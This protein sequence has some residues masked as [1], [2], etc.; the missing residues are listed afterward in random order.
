MAFG[1]L[2]VLGL[3]QGLCE[4]LP[5]SSSGHLVLLSSLFGI[6]DS[7]LVSVILH[8]ATLLAVLI[9]FRKDLWRMIKNPLSNEVIRLAI[10]TICTC[11]IAMLLM[12]ALKNSFAGSVLPVT[13]ALSGV[14]LFVTEK[15]AKGKTGKPISYKQSIVIGIAQ[16]IALLPG[17]SR[18]G[19]T[20]AAGIISGGDK[21]ECAK[22][23]FLLSIPTILGSLLLEII[24]LCKE[25]A[26]VQMNVGGL[27]CGCVIA[28]AV[29]LAS[30]KFMINLT[31]KTN[32]KWFALY[33]GI[34]AVVSL[35]IF[36]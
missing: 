21:K 9:A 23:S 36:W 8:V 35:F 30:I 22:F 32:F 14:I 13:F 27:V 24:D 28:F 2:V 11:L 31:E 10:S 15:M 19:T 34:M 7:L 5:V 12:P 16:G 20:I 33:L 17:V 25:G 1:V 6:S 29:A 18:S 26:N 3:V 4:F